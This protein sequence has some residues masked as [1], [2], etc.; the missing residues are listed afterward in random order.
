[1]RSGDGKKRWGRLRRLLKMLGIVA[2]FR[3]LA[4]LLRP[5]PPV[6]DELP[7]IKVDLLTYREV[8]RYFTEDRPTDP[9]IVGGALL[10]KRK[11]TRTSPRYEQL[12]IND[13]EQ[14]VTDGSGEMYGRSVRA[15]QVDDELA[16]AF[17]SPDN[18]L[19]IFR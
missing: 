17:G 19:V 11:R 1:M 9:T 7:E 16:A 5:S 12:F 14:P 8:V 13:K 10:R 3:W 2:I 4:S 15:A 18:D 6:T